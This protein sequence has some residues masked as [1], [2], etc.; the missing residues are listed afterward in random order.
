MEGGVRSKKIS[1]TM[2]EAIKD[3]LYDD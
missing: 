2:E 3:D 1:F